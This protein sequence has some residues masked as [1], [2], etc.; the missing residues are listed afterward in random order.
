MKTSREEMTITTQ[1]E[2]YL[3]FVRKS[4]DVVL[5]YNNQRHL[6]TS[7]QDRISPKAMCD[8]AYLLLNKRQVAAWILKG[9]LSLRTFSTFAFR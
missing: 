5:E 8:E 7:M 6:Y 2:S 1:E 4:A 9:A 3:G